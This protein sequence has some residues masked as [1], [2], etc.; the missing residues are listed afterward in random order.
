MILGA[1]SLW[2]VAASAAFVVEATTGVRSI[3][4]SRASVF[5]G[6]GLVLSVL[7]TAF[8]SL[9]GLVRAAFGGTRPLRSS[10]EGDG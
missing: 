5:V 2:F 1:P 6:A 10:R 8:M 3:V 4:S 9:D 7:V